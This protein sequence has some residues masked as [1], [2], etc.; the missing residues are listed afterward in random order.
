[1]EEVRSLHPMGGREL[2]DEA[3]HLYKQNLLLFFG[4]GAVVIV[5][6]GLISLALPAGV[7]EDVDPLAYFALPLVSYG[8]LV[9][10][11]AD[12][13]LGRAVSIASA[14]RYVVRRLIP[15]ALTLVL[16]GLLCLCL[17]LGL[18]WGGLLLARDPVEAQQIAALA[19]VTALVAA[20]VLFVFLPV[21]IVIEE[22]YYWRA[23][24]RSWGLSRG[25]RLRAIWILIFAWLL[26]AALLLFLSLTAGVLFVVA[27]FEL[28]GYS[29]T[30]P[31]GEQMMDRAFSLIVAV[32]L[33]A[34]APIPALSAV[35]LYFDVRVRKEGY[36]IELLVE[37]G[38]QG[39]PGSRPPGAPEQC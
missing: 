1:M 12:R 38:M 20:Q 13:F 36:D 26:A 5:P 33:A 32:S 37:Q 17:F 22:A 14:W 24:R 34:T 16:P 30:S 8:A 9:N 21:V 29:S 4:I 6:Y 31:T 18:G 7:A 19:A 3:V 35:L 10:A 15:A 25:H 23:I 39:A 28:S 11:F 2:F 27:P